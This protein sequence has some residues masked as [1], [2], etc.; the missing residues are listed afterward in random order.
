MKILY[1]L[2]P[3]LLFFIAYKFFDIYVA[4]AVAISAALL[5]LVITWFTRRGMDYLQLT[6]SV[7]IIVFGSMTL[8]F[9]NPLF[10]KLKPSIIN[11]VLAIIFFGSH[12]FGKKPIVQ[13]VLEGS[14]KMYPQHWLALSWRWILFFLAIGFANLYAFSHYTTDQWVNFKVFGLSIASIAFCIY[15]A[16]FIHKHSA[17][18][19]S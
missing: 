7:L 3:I 17:G 5:Q 4:T 14:V 19:P 9:H 8:Y 11:W 18:K 6:T 13:Q 15:Q 1:D 12:Y 2:F 10:I 16:Y